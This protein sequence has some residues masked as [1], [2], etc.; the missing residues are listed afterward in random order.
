MFLILV[1]PLTTNNSVQKI[2]C[3]CGL[4]FEKMAAHAEHSKGLS[5]KLVVPSYNVL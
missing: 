4:V 5:E 3:E 1:G 2:I